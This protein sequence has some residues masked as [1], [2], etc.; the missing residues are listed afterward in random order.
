MVVHDVSMLWLIVDGAIF[1]LGFS[2]VY[3]LM[4]KLFARWN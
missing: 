1:A 4:S 3:F 2:P